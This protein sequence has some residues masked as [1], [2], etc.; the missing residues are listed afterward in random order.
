MT[1]KDSE[2]SH[3]S[4]T[5]EEYAERRTK[6]FHSLLETAIKHKKIT[7]ED[8]IELL[9]ETCEGNVYDYFINVHDKLIAAAKDKEIQDLQDRL[10][11]GAEKI[12]AETDEKK[13]QKMLRLYDE[14]EKNIK[15]L[16][17]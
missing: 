3:L 16:K 4:E 10:V 7:Q 12:E 5:M 6:E 15:E 13:K 11:K 8:Y 2:L 14:I 17:K 9:L 1:K